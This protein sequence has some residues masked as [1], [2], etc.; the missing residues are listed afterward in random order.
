MLHV[1]VS[2]YLK[3]QSN[4]ILDAKSRSKDKNQ[5]FY[6]YSLYLFPGT[7]SDRA[8]S[9]WMPR[10][11]AKIGISCLTHAPCFCFQVP[12]ET[13]QPHPG[14]QEQEQERRQKKI[15]GYHWKGKTKYNSMAKKKKRTVG[16]LKI[17]RYRGKDVPR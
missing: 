5:L 16:K 13:E 9:S 8:T 4:L 6:K 10:A 14:C 3:R 7:S 17:W 2:R 11:G 1:S 12:Q 15:D